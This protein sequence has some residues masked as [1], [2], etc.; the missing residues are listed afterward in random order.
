MQ[1][2]GNYLLLLG[3]A[4][5]GNT[6][7]V[8]SI[9][10]DYAVANDVTVYNF[11]TKLDGG[12]AKKY[13]G[14]SGDVH[15][16]DSKNVFA[17]LYVDLVNTY[18]DN[19]ETE[20]T[21]ESGNYIYYLSDPEDES[22]EVI[23]NKLQVPYF[24]AYNKDTVDNDGHDTPILSYVEKMYVL[25]ETKESYINSDANYADYTAAA[26]NVITAYAEKT[27][28]TAKDIVTK[29]DT[30]GDN[31]AITRDASNNDTTVADTDSEAQ[32]GGNNTKLIVAI[33]GIVVVI[34]VIVF[35]VIGKKKSS[36][37]G[38]C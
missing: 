13:W 12:Y 28:I 1:Q 11:D 21:V 18:F 37:G 27:G 32:N 22:T 36:V 26:F 15:I 17:N 19:I 3:G 31:A 35:A 25:D 2:E 5:C 20:Y 29:T 10:N 6:Q 34:G 24:L 4:W 8:I 16:R 23:A 7:A 30:S 38:K 33:V 9:I 14:Y